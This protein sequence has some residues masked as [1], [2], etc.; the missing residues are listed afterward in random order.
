[1]AAL[2]CKVKAR[3]KRTFANTASFSTLSTIIHMH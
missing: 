1:M 3:S 2:L